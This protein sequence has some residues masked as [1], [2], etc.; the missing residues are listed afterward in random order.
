MKNTIPYLTGLFRL[1]SVCALL[2]LCG[3]GTQDSSELQDFAAD[4]RKANQATEIEPMLALYELEGSTQPTINFL[5]NALFY[6]LGLP[7]K[8]IEFEP[9]SGAP[10]E[11]IHYQ[12]QGIE[13]VATLE[14]RH[15]MRVRYDTEDHLES[16]FTIGQNAKGE[17]RIVSSRPQ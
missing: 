3:C 8:R 5:K 4:F 6:E 10:E 9:L 1:L 17:W 7:I 14:P 16:L 2:A 15:R 11:T 12:H 13:Y